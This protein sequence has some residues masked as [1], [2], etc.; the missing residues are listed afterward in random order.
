MGSRG[1]GQRSELAELAELPLCLP[2]SVLKCHKSCTGS[3][4][5]NHATPVFVSHHT[6][7]VQPDF[8]A[9]QWL[10]TVKWPTK[11]ALVESPYRLGLQADKLPKRSMLPQ[12]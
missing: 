7:G 1:S 6:P 3:Q 12:R 8:V 11:S 5:N 2:E 9:T 10:R 4:S